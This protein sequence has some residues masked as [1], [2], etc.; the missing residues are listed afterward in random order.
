MFLVNAL[1]AGLAIGAGI[2]LFVVVSVIGP[3]THWGE[4]SQGLIY[5]QVCK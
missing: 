4:V 3:P 5:H 2:I 1:A